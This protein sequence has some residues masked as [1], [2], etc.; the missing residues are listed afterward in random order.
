MTLVVLTVLVY[1]YA[2]V[3]AEALARAKQE[4]TRILAD[5]GLDAVWRDGPVTREEIVAYP[6]DPSGNGSVPLSLRLM[7][8]GAAAP[9]L[10]DPMDPLL[11]GFALRP[12]DVAVVLT[13]RVEELAGGRARFYPVLLGH[14][15]AHELGHL[16]L[17]DGEHFPASIM[18]YPWRRREL[19]R[20]AQG[21]MRF[22]SWQR[23][24]MLEQMR[25]RL[26]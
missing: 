8:A 7:R 20:V 21:T 19:E 16:L 11:F 4:A 2:G 25:P 3:P 10:A 23:Q 15:M 17:K 6:Q 22:T 18:T 1:N 5:A 13:E 26:D 9:L 14:I 12:G 24:R